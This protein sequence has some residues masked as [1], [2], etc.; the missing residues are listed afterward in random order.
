[1]ANQK[2]KES[3]RRSKKIVTQNYPTLK[4]LV[5][6][7]TPENRRSDIPVGAERGKEKVVW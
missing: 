4:D 2:E 1:M 3:G 6:K 5:P 7:I